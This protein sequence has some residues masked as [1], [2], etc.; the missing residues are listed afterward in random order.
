M[1]LKEII[2]SIDGSVDPRFESFDFQVKG[3]SCDSRQVKEGFIFVAIEGSRLSGSAFIGEALKNGAQAVV[4]QAAV[5]EAGGRPKSEKA[6]FITVNDARLALAR[7]AAAFY[8]NPSSKVKVIGITG[9]NGKT[10]VSYLIE[11]ILLE[12]GLAPAVIGTVNYRFKGKVLAS[13]NTTPG[14]VELQ[15]MLADMSLQGVQY[16]I[17]EVSSHSLHQY[18]TEAVDFHSAIFT[19]L[20]QDHLDYHGTLENYFE[21]K[22]RLFKGLSPHAFAVINNDDEYARRVKDFCKADIVT[23]GMRRE[24]D[25]TAQNIAMDPA[26]AEFLLAAKDKEVRLRT[27]LIGHHNVYNILASVAWAVKEGIKIETICSAIEKFTCV[28]GRLERIKSRKDFWVFVD[29]AHTEDA[30]RNVIMSLRRI[31]KKRI[32]TV[33]G[34][35]GERDKTKRP[36]MGQAAVEL[37]DR[38]I[39]TDDNPR[40][41]DPH[42]IIEDIKSG[43]RKDNYSVVRD[44]LEAIKS[45]LALAEPG[46]IVLIAGKGHEDYQVYKDK[47]IHFDDREAVKECLQS[48]S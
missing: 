47:T 34:C 8:G 42:A 32:I 46:D 15:S 10:T 25:V 38:V 12:A 39:I 30:L 37:S 29:Y 19:N 3:I 24:S 35:G 43:I 6:L 17:L 36:K 44:R 13:R 14:P 41:E 16:A 48:M 5:R 18:R 27:S 22:A 21:A 2:K 1:E 20:T 4:T 33:F 40:S 11:A 26:Y 45:A 31:G 9:T 7:L 23:F 28:P